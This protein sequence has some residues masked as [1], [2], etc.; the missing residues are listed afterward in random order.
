MGTRTSAYA[1]FCRMRRRLE[2]PIIPVAWVLT[3]GCRGWPEDEQGKHLGHWAAKND[4]RYQAT[5]DWLAEQLGW[6][7]G[8]PWAARPEGQLEE[9]V[10]N[11]DDKTLDDLGTI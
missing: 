7:P 6:K 4:N 3:T 5:A 2:S 9:F 11:A 1:F 8:E 10:A